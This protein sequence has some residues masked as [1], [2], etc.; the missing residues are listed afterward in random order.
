MTVL[1]T[2]VVPQRID[3]VIECATE[4][5]CRSI[6]YRKTLSLHNEANCEM[7]HNVVYNTSRKFLETNI[8]FDHVHLENPEKV[9][10][11]N[12]TL[13]QTVYKFFR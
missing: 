1:M 10:T 11:I 13:I 12:Q 2:K 4:P 5:C 3:C 8:S 9:N 6:N 7:L